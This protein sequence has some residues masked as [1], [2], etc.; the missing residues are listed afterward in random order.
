VSHAEIVIADIWRRYLKRSDIGLDDDF[1][2]SGG[3]SLQATEML[4]ELE[5]ATQQRV[6]PSD[7]A[8]QLTI[9]RLYEVL[10]SAATSKE[11]LLTKVKSG[12]GTPLF[13]CHGD[14][15]GGGLY[16]YRLARLLDGP[17]YLLHSA[18]DPGKGTDSFEQMARRYMPDIVAAAPHGRVR[19]AG[20]CNGGLAALEVAHQ[21]E[22]RGRSVEH[23]ILIDTFSINARP[24][25]RLLMRAV[26]LALRSIP[27]RFGRTIRS[28]TVTSLWRT[29]G[30]ILGGDRALAKRITRTLQTGKMKLWD[31]SERTGYFQAMAEYL[32][33][34]LATEIICLR[35]EEYGAKKEHAPEPWRHLARAVRADV[36]PGDH[37]TCI[38][39]HAGDLATCINRMMAPPVADRV[40][41]T[42]HFEQEG[43]SAAL[44]RQR[45]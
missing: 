9:R 13:L 28:R 43:R 2:E 21:I 23:V 11:E 4:L 40:S 30:Y 19:L 1:F 37:N 6:A 25:M 36:I 31:D 26:L 18:L 34:R 20:F 14:Y 44:V 39:R 15:A 33:P 41:A 8:A 29:A 32:P 12:P 10:A 5:E 24:A 45:S 7:V 35:C 22:A 3:D 38:S 42:S 27:G 17:I 16:A